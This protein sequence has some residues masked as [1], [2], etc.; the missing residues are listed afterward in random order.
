MSPKIENWHKLNCRLFWAYEG[1]VRAKFQHGAYRQEGIV[2]WLINRGSVR[3]TF[4]HSVEQCEAGSWYF[5]KGEPWTQDFSSDA[6]ILSLRFIAHWPDET[7]L[8]D[9]SRSLQIPAAEVPRLT[10]LARRMARYVSLNH[11]EDTRGFEQVPKSLDRY[12]D[13]QRLFLSWMTT[14][15][16]LM[17]THHIP[18]S[19]HQQLDERVWIAINRIE[20][21]ELHE[22]LRESELAKL[23][24]VSKSH[25]NR[26]FVINTGK[27]PADYW[28][29]RRVQAARSALMESGRSVKTIAYE[30]GFSSL[31]HFSTWVR[32]K[33]GRSPRALRQLPTKK[34]DSSRKPASDASTLISPHV[35][36]AR[37]RTKRPR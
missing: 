3:L 6:E 19:T 32:K 1:P 36:F 15:V 18:S 13:M 16:E 17:R 34:K 7:A 12:I 5:P 28:A 27:T 8:F 4:A 33:T 35:A 2:A 9:R 30:L 23:A 24:G 29:D 25:L 37:P 31:S 11:V 21:A 20:R 14:Y 10:S 26:M 22:P